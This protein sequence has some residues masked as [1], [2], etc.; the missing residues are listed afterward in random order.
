MCVHTHMRAHTDACTYTH[1]KHLGMILKFH[2]HFF[3]VLFINSMLEEYFC[4]DSYKFTFCSD[5]WASAYVTFLK[6]RQ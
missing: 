2:S 4:I 1:I 3:F 6:F 5:N